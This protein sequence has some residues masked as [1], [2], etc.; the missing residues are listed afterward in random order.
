M[1]A[2]INILLI[3]FL[4]F[5]SITALYFLIPPTFSLLYFLRKL[6][7]IKDAAEKFPFLTDKNFEFGIIITA[8][9]QTEFITPLVDSI[10]KQQYN[11]YHVYI[12][13][14]ACDTSSLRFMDSR[15]TILKPITPLN[16][17]IKSIDFA[18]GHFKG[19]HDAMII[20]D[21]DNLIHPGFLE[22]MNNYF[23]KGFRAVQADF[24]AKNTDTV[25]AR[26]DAIGDA[27]NFFVE[28]EMRMELGLSAAIWGSGIAIDLSLYKEVIYNNFLGGFDKKLQAHLIQRLPMIAFAKEAILYDEK[29]SSG[30]SLENQ[31]TRWINA[32]FKYLR[33]GFSLFMKGLLKGNFNQA[34]FAFIT[35][36]PPMFMLILLAFVFT[37]VNFFIDYRL[38]L[39]WLSIMV[40]FVISFV[41]IILIR[42]KERKL[43]GTLL[44]L[45][46]FM[47]RQ[48]FAF[49]KIG[50][51]NKSFLKTRHSKVVFI[52]DVLRQTV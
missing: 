12:V 37:V 32:Q 52:E 10:L 40:L 49:L 31:R 34:Y 43:I 3:L 44:M 47:A 41:T 16:S 9:E 20:F 1:Q 5:Q 26:M 14:D 46:V 7:R 18:L 29:I 33:M 19:N 36:R 17:K 51:A 15:I 4:I 21:S 45:P 27:F 24:R 39:V 6:F 8:H 35:I 22:T 11:N 50:R 48:A 38:S 28:R 13:A 25:Y 2:M 30:K 23:R 42:D